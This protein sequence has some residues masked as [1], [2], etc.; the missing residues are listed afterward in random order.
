MPTIRLIIGAACV[1]VL[2]IAVAIFN[3]LY[4]V[5]AGDEAVVLNFGSPAGTV[6]PGLHVRTPIV[7]SVALVTMQ[8]HYLDFAEESYSKDQQPADIKFSVNF[9]VL[10]GSASQVVSE[11]TTF[12]TL[13]DRVLK[14]KGPAVF[15]NVFGGYDAQ[16]AVQARAKLNSDFLTALQSSVDGSPLVIESVQVKDIKYSPD[17]EDAIKKK[18][19]ATVQVEQQKQILAQEQV[20]ATIAVTQAQAQADSQLAIARNGAAAT[21]LQ[22]DADAYAIE[23]KAKALAAYPTYSAYITARNWDGKLPTT[24]PPGGTVPFINIAPAP[25]Q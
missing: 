14:Q 5:S 22:G 3:P 13:V 6:G 12:D 9:H 19:Q 2:L 7:Q 1:A 18:Q 16:T 17:Y 21:K 11:Y 8:S 10:P 23:V 24:I 25:V 4:T 20:K 15:K